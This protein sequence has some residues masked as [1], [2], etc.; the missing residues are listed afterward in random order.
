MKPKSIGIVGGAGPLAG[1]LLLQRIFSLSGS[2]Y[3]CY[4]DADFPE[5][6]LLSFPFSEMLLENRDISQLKKELKNCLTR[7][8]QNGASILAIACNT[9][10]CFLEEES[11]LDLVNL[12]K[13]LATE[14]PRDSLPLVF[15]TA[16]SRQCGLHKQF[17]PC[18]YPGVKTQKQIDDVIEL[19]LKGSQV[20]IVLP[21]LRRIMR[22]QIASTIVL[23]CTELSLY[24]SALQSCR[25]SILDPLEVAARK[26]LEK[27]F[28][29]ITRS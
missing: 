17:F 16:T 29:N 14:V 1:L 5:V 28:E 25:K 7:L 13:V 27:S 15:C 12:P 23:G 8:R 26:I 9:L 22:S 6:Q 2:I 10:H 20:K 21:R 3:G 18:V 24:S 19:I 11:E 4:K